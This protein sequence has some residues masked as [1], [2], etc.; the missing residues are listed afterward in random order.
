MS[1]LRIGFSVLKLQLFVYGY[2]GLMSGAAGVVQSWTVMTVAPDSLLGY[3]LT[4]LAAVVLG[5]NGF[6]WRARH[7]NRYFA[8]RGVVGSDAKRAKF[9]GSLCLTGKH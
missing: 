1:Q 9:I 3:E 6:R 2:M 4:V 7:V 8:R 5:G